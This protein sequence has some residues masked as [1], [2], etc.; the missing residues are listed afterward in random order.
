MGNNFFEL[1][2][3]IAVLEISAIMAGSFFMA[4]IILAYF[5]STI[6]PFAYMHF[7]TRKHHA[8]ICHWQESAKPLTSRLEDEQTAD[9]HLGGLARF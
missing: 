9:E 7:P 2:R 3:A 4:T 1:R 8:K 5:V 6:R